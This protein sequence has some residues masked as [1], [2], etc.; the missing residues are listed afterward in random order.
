[1]NLSKIKWTATH[2][3]GK[4]ITHPKKKWLIFEVKEYKLVTRDDLIS[5][6]FWKRKWLF[7]KDII[8]ETRRPNLVGKWVIMWRL[9]T[10]VEMLIVGGI[11]KKQRI[12]ERFWIIEQ[13]HG[14]DI[15]RIRENGAIERLQSYKEI[16]INP[17]KAEDLDFL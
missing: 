8:L 13:G 2:R 6:V 3:D 4:K 9:R 1:M 7:W 16:D 12:K 17:I 11:K 5:L 14:R 15:I 10:Q